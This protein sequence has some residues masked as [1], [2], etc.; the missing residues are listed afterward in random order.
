MLHLERL[1]NTFNQLIKIKTFTEFFVL[2]SRNPS[3][4]H[5]YKSIGNPKPFDVTLRDGL[6]ALSKEEEKIFTTERK[7][8]L[9]NEI[10][11][12]HSPKNIEIGSFVNEKI[13]PIFRDSGDLL[14]YLYNN[15]K[16]YN[17]VNN[18]VL[19][20][21]LI[22]LQ[23]ALN[24][25]AKNF[26]LI[27][28]VSDSFQRKNTKMSLNESL[29][30]IS[31]IMTYLDDYNY[32]KINSETEEIIYNNKINKIKIYISC[33]NHCPIEGEIKLSRIISQ[34]IK[35]NKLKPTTICLS[36]T[37]GNLTAENFNDIIKYCKN[38]E[39]D[40]KKFSLHLHIHP[41]RE[42]EAEKIV[43]LALDNG[44]NEFDV[45][46]LTTGG[47]SLTIDKSNIAPNMNYE[48]YYKFLINYLIKSS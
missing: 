47:C 48:Q 19:I 4:M 45:S 29:Q 24:R 21:N 7:I 20:P 33:I 16:N 46:Y 9:Y 30:N 42:E 41:D 27:T 44:I 31:D 3:L 13:L 6:Q 11:V 28:S 39:I 25:G 8:A 34:I 14:D 43:F 2:C 32:C 37:C 10:L 38:L 12:N 22:Q 36:D 1:P 40:I 23:N 17:N 35:I 18:Y 15:R 5:I 26:S